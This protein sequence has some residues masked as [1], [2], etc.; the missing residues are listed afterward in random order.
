MRANLRAVFAALA[1]VFIFSGCATEKRS[2]EYSVDVKHIEPA[3]NSMMERYDVVKEMAENKWDTFSEDEQKKLNLVANYVRLIDARVLR[4]RNKHAD[5][6]EGTR[7][8]VPELGYI[9]TLARDA[10]N[11]SYGIATNHMA[12]LSV[13]DVLTLQNFN[14]QLL[15][16]DEEIKALTVTPHYNDVD[17]IL[18]NML[19][20]SS[21]ALKIIIP[22]V[23][24][25][26]IY[27]GPEQ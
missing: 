16:L 5:G 7:V 21:A 8:T 17:H 13:T 4:I 3:Y 6:M 22:V 11:I 15:E 25:R 10:Y 27:A 26:E 18:Y 14:V 19:N 2:F 1:V 9:Y 23:L 20:I 12:E 24:G